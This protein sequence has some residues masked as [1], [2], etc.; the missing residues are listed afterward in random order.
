MCIHH[1]FFTVFKKGR[2]SVRSGCQMHHSLPLLTATTLYLWHIISLLV[3]SIEAFLF[4][5]LISYISSFHGDT[6]FLHSKSVTVKQCEN[7]PTS[8][9]RLTLDI[10][11]QHFHRIP[12]TTVCVLGLIAE[13]KLPPSSPD[14]RDGDQVHSYESI[15]RSPCFNYCT[16]V[17][18]KS[19]GNYG[20][21]IPRINTTISPSTFF[22]PQT[23][24]KLRTCKIN[25]TTC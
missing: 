22:P 6:T 17:I 16:T 21:I 8:E 9:K 24:E 18:I 14:L 7:K 5:V 12:R 2:P 1:H 15:S 20:N 4:W 25:T 11:K 3:I 19:R 13:A 23:N 10:A